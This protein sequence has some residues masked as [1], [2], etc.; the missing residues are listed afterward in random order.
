MP[1]KVSSSLSLPVSLSVYVCVFGCIACWVRFVVGG[2]GD[3]IGLGEV[4]RLE[5][6]VFVCTCGSVCVLCV[7]VCVCWTCWWVWVAVES[8]HE[9]YIKCQ[10]T[11]LRFLFV[12]VEGFR[13]WL[14][15]M[16]FSS[17]EI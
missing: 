12:D 16:N 14:L 3:I 1:A 5:N 8:T 2:E 17:I 10:R 13:S 15:L 6:A 11:C 9:L 7:C 4:D